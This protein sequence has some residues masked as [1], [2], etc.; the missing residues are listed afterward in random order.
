MNTPWSFEDVIFRKL[1][2]CRIRQAFF[3]A[4]ATT[5]NNSLEQNKQGNYDWRRKILK[6]GSNVDIST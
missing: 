1:S 4:D 2:S 6:T 3:Q 5:N